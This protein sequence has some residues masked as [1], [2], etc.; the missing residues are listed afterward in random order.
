MSVVDVVKLSLPGTKEEAQEYVQKVGAS[1]NALSVQGQENAEALKL[2]AAD[3]KAGLDSVKKTQADAELAL[4][5]AANA[6]AL[7]KDGA[8]TVPGG[9]EKALKSMTLKYDVNRDETFKGQ[10][11]PFIYNLMSLSREELAELP[12]ET[13]KPV[14]RFLRLWSALS[15]MDIYQMHRSPDPRMYLQRGGWKTLR[16]ADEFIALSKIFKGVAMD[17]AED[18]GGLQW[19]PTGVLPSLILDVR[20]EFSVVNNIPQVPLARSPI[21][22]PVQREYIR[23]FK[24]AE[25][26]AS[27]GQT[28]MGT[29]NIPTANV[30]FT[31]AMCN[32]LL[33]YSTEFEDDAIVEL[34]SVVPA[35]ARTGILASTEASWVDGQLSAVID[36]GDATITGTDDRLMYDG[37][38]YFQSL[39]GVGIDAGSGLTV[40]LCNTLAAQMG[41]YG[42]NPSNRFWVTGYI[43][44][45]KFLTL[46]DSA[47]TAVYTTNEKAGSNATAQTGTLGSVLGSPLC[48]SDIYRQ[49]MNNAG[50][51]DGAVTDRTSVLLACKGALRHGVVRAIRLEPSAHQ[52]FQ[53]NQMAFRATYR[54]QGKAVRTPASTYPIVGALYNVPTA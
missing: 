24:G 31:A 41:R 53:F 42:Y 47:G 20:P 23:G 34:A 11:H 52:F 38:R 49:D 10:L 26:T 27:T 17:E 18:G 21:L 13:Q 46:K 8:R 7:A 28:Q 6:E 30:T 3:L 44:W 19:V 54:A 40:E 37:L 2:V 35:E 48:V 9:F 33:V 50:V 51:Y 16:G 25:A 45:A 22:M 14:E 39:T 12:E 29:R 1:L 43:G 5:K 36:T 32:V 15:V 4:E